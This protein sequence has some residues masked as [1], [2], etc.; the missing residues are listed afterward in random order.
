VLPKANTNLAPTTIA[1]ANGS[2]LSDHQSRATSAAPVRRPETPQ[3]VVSSSGCLSQSQAQGM[4]E[5][6]ERFLFIYYLYFYA[7]HV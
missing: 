6:S 7:S 3:L 1:A 2:F 5:I 4:K